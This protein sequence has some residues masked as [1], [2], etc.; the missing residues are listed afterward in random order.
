MHLLPLYVGSAIRFMA[1]REHGTRRVCKHPIGCM[2]I[3]CQESIPS[4][5]AQDDPISI[6]LV[7]CFHRLSPMQAG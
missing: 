4:L 6:D 3:Q 5:C 2:L 7:C 1:K